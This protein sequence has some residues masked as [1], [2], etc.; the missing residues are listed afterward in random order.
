MFV[1][2]N[3]N[4]K[5]L[6]EKVEISIISQESKLVSYVFNTVINY[7]ASTVLS[8]LLFTFFFFFNR[9]N[10]PAKYLGQEL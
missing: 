7:I 9:M 2:E 6:M 5:I 8:C 1:T 4:M 10:I 3:K